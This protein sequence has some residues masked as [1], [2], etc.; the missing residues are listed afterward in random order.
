MLTKLK[1]LLWC[2]LVL[3]IT[4]VPLMAGGNDPKT[5]K[6]NAVDAA[7]AGRRAGESEPCSQ[8]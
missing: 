2:L 6:G 5:A 8:A 3:A 7:E 4:A 1:Q